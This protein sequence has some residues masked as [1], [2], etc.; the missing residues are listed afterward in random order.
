MSYIFRQNKKCIYCLSD[1]PDKPEP[2]GKGMETVRASGLIISGKNS[3]WFP[4][5]SIYSTAY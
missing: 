5:L 1:K 3:V 4:Y 2:F